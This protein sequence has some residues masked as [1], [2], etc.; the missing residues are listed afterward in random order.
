MLILAFK[1]DV[2][3]PLR[4]NIKYKLHNIVELK[5]AIQG[6]LFCGQWKG[7]GRLY[8]TKCYWPHFLRF[9]IHTLWKLWKSTFSITPL[10]FDTSSPRNHRKYPH[11]PYIVRN[12][13]HCATSLLLIVWV[14]LY[15]NFRGGL[16]KRIYVETECEMAIQGRP[17]SLILVP[18]EA[19]MQLPISHQ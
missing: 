1:Q 19:L 11:K 15:L 2:Y 13:S 5:M 12:Y 10:S 9:R 18:I 6:H 14:Y 16:R 7:G 4:Q 17:R 3:S 8:N